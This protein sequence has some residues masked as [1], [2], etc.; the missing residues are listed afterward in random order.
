MNGRSQ[1]FKIRAGPTGQIRFGIIHRPDSKSDELTRLWKVVDWSF[2]SGS[3]ET[4]ANE[5][6]LC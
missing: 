1:L 2:T 5:V 4:L 6:F 3:G